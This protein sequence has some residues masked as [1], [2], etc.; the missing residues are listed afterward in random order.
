MTPQSAEDIL[1]GALASV[2][3]VTRIAPN[4]IRSSDRTHEVVRARY[5]VMFRAHRRR[6]N[7]TAIA[8]WFNCDH[9]TVHHGIQSIERRLR[10]LGC[11]PEEVDAFVDGFVGRMVKNDNPL[12]PLLEAEA[13]QRGLSIDELAQRLLATAILDGLVDAIL[14]DTPKEDAA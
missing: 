1:R 4:V 13:L 14:D 8:R 5:T 9:T 2:A 3:A 11:A 6:V 12:V 10:Q 7:K